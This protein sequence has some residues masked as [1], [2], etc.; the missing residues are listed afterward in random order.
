MHFS[1]N[2]QLK[3]YKYV[4]FIHLLSAIK[5]INNNNEHFVHSEIRKRWAG[6]VAQQQ[7][8]SLASLKLWIQS[9]ELVL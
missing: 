3:F 4:Y 1:R 6:E 5:I 7:N 8:I 9:P 2:Y